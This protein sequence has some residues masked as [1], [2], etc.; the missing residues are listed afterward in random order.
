ME[1]FRETKELKIMTKDANK[2]QQKELERQRYKDKKKE[3]Q[4]QNRRICSPRV[5]ISMDH[6]I[7]AMRHL[8]D[9]MGDI[10]NSN[11]L[12]KRERNELFVQIARYVESLTK[13][14]SD[15]A[16]PEQITLR[17]LDQ[18]LTAIKTLAKKLCNYCLMPDILA[19]HNLG[20]T[21]L[22]ILSFIDQEIQKA[23]NLGKKQENEREKALKRHI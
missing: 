22:F 10:I 8:M 16:K 6:K 3:E 2:E 14:R 18:R 4:A 13:A 7:K 17:G 5:P 15:K 21:R 9:I 20:I 11:R 1:D 23:I 19:L 12:E